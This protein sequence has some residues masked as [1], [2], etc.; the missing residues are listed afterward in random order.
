[1]I[2][3]KDTVICPACGGTNSED[4]VFCANS[5]CHKALGEFNYVLEELQ[6]SKSRL[7]RLADRVTLFVSKPHFV[8]V[9]LLWFLSWIL[10]NSGVAGFFLVFDDY[11]YSLLGIVLA[12]EAILITGFVLISQ[13]RQYAYSEKRAELD[14]EV[15]VR[16]YRKLIEL[17]QRKD[18]F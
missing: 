8:T 11:P 17:E 16:S 10:V 5:E 4:A 14:Y 18:D 15:S 7:E 1:M 9:H 2:I 13:S 6:Q 3:E 12:I